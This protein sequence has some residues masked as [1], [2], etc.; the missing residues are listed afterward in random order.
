MTVSES[1]TRYMIYK[2]AAG[3]VFDSGKRYLISLTRRLGDID[4]KL[5]KVE[6]VMAY[7]DDSR[8]QGCAWRLKYGVFVGF[9]DFWASVGRC[10]FCHF[11]RR[12]QE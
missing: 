9:F 11:P 2:N 10:H 8:G 1:I 3:V 5:V 12:N 7:L 4:L 6:D